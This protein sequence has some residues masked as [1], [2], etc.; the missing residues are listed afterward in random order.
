MRGG[1][2][3]VGWIKNI[4]SYWKD[5]NDFSVSK[6]KS[7]GRWKKLIWLVVRVEFWK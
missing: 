3:E 2:R 7:G 5:T 1:A 6:V 4:C